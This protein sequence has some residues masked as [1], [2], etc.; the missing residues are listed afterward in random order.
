MLP[1][2]RH[3]FVG[4]GVLW[5]KPE[6]KKSFGYKWSLSGSSWHGNFFARL[7]PFSLL[8]HVLRVFI[9]SWSHS[10]WAS[11]FVSSCLLQTAYHLVGNM[12][13]VI[14]IPKK[15]KNV[16]LLNKPNTW[17]VSHINS[18]LSSGSF[19][20][21]RQIHVFV[22]RGFLHEPWGCLSGNPLSTPAVD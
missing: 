12:A 9:C 4:D 3:S 18:C 14:G 16:W 20:K 6:S 10:V 5:K 17:D 21:G 11:W 22:W 2:S 13:L 19:R 15:K 8:V 1:D 7:F